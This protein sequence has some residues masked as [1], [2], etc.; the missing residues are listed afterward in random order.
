MVAK[1][2]RSGAAT[3]WSAAWSGAVPE[4]GSRVAQKR[5]SSGCRA[6]DSCLSSGEEAL[7]AARAVSAASAEASPPDS[8]CTAA[9]SESAAR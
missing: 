1:A 8:A 3:C 4:A 9:F 5:A 7:L 6:A 2:A